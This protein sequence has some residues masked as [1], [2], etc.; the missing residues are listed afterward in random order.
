MKRLAILCIITML[1][2]KNLFAMEKNYH[3]FTSANGYSAV[4]FDDISKRVKMFF[5]HI[6]KN[7][8]KNTEVNNIAFDTYFGLSLDGENFWLPERN[9]AYSSLNYLEKTGIIHTVSRFE[10]AEVEEFIFAPMSLEVSSM[11]MLIKVKALAD[12]QSLSIFSIHNFHLGLEENKVNFKSERILYD[13][14]DIYIE[15]SETSDYI[16]AYKPLVPNSIHSTNPI[17]PYNVVKSGGTLSNVSDSKIVDDAV[18]GFEMDYGV[19]KSGESRWF[20]VLILYKDN[21]DKDEI[22]NL[23]NKLTENKNVEDFL[24]DEIEFWNNHFNI[25]DQDI[26]GI[27]D[28]D[29]LLYN[30]AALLK[31]SQVREKNYE[32]RKPN[33]QILASL[34]PGMWNITW[35]RDMMYSIFALVEIGLREDALNGLKF[36]LNA[37]C[38]Y[39]KEYVG[40]D[41]KFSVCRYYGD[42]MEESDVN[43]DGPNIEFDGPGLFLAGVGSYV[44][45]YG[46][47]E[48]R[49]YSD[50]IFSNFADVILSLIDSEGLIKADSSI[51]ERHLNGKEKHFTYTQITALAGL[52][53]AILFADKLGDSKHLSLYKEAYYRL[54]DNV[55]EKLIHKDG[56]LVSSLEEYRALAGFLDA[57]VIEAI[58]LGVISGNDLFSK[59]TMDIMSLLKTAGGGYK[60]NDDGDWYD[61]QEW[62]FI[63]LRIAS[64]YKKIGREDIA[65]SIIDRVKSYVILN[66]YQFPELI[67]EDG[68][69]IAGSVPMIGFGAGAYILSQL[70]SE[71]KSCISEPS[72]ASYDSN[73]TDENG[74]DVFTDNYSAEDNQQHII[75]SVTIDSGFE[76]G[77]PNNNPSCSCN[78]LE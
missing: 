76:K 40:T 64:A 32:G 36:I 50:I 23:A 39:F 53:G 10:K 71:F 66:N 67:T 68:N 13:S 47:D 77:S 55:L 20:G 41:Y 2:Y 17:N 48:L 21:K 12:L 3:Y 65:K 74:E 14:S 49:E 11:L 45:R 38:G 33:G 61:K 59:K 57:A 43:E 1:F 6:Y 52:C 30:A 78:Y 34:P 22:I 5:P 58:N 16:V 73:F 72:D 29:P 44:S 28:K 25:V 42:G 7:F 9:E 69:N 37:D 18:C 27:F 24:N 75:D 31:M 19:V 26:L 46:V 8:D 4:V 56:Y 70:N 51:W 60:R 62:V 15:S 35:L 63:D 54:R